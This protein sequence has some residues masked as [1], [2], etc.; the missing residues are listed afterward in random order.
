MDLRRAAVSLREAAAQKGIPVK[1]KLG[2]PGSFV[3]RKDGRILFSHKTD[4]AL[5][6]TDELLQR[7]S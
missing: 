3:L 1:I 4:G 2:A 7:I 5:P 6:T